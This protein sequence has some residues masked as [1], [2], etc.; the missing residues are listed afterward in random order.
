MIGGDDA[1]PGAWPWQVCELIFSNSLKIYQ[2]KRDYDRD[3]VKIHLHLVLI[4]TDSYDLIS[5]FSG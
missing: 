5:P 4:N 3:C 1:I 2:V